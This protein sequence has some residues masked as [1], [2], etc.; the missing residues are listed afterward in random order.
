[1]TENIIINCT[2]GS[3]PYPLF[4]LQPISKFFRDVDHDVVNIPFSLKT[5]KV[6]LE[7]IIHRLQ[8]KV[9]NNKIIENIWDV[10]ALQNYLNLNPPIIILNK[11]LLQR[12]NTID[13]FQKFLEHTPIA[14]IKANEELIGN[15]R[16]KAPS[17]TIY[18]ILFFEKFIKEGE[19][20]SGIVILD[21]L[22]HNWSLL[23]AYCLSKLHYPIDDVLK[24]IDH[25]KHCLAPPTVSSFWKKIISNYKLDDE[26]KKK[27]FKSI[28]CDDDH[29]YSL[30]LDL[31]TS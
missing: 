16:L 13:E 6:I 15:I 9:I 5:L 29:K 18:I 14:D 26:M 30:A 4:I 20:H 17:T 25:T 1:M 27:L 21:G 8:G 11:D 23:Y 10:Y 2:D 7:G 31:F 22:R 3:L 28:I 19:Q 24:V 12:A